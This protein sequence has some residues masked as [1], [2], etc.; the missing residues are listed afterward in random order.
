ML[1]RSTECPWRAALWR[2]SQKVA[3]NARTAPIQTRIPKVEESAGIP[4]K[5]G[6]CD[7]VVVTSSLGSLVAD[8]LAEFG[9]GP[10]RSEI[11]I[12]DRSDDRLG[13]LDDG[14]TRQNA[15]SA[16]EGID[17]DERRNLRLLVHK[18]VG[19]QFRRLVDE[20]LVQLLPL[21]LVLRESGRPILALLIEPG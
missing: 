3:A 5:L 7:V 15:H 11:G 16:Y 13:L 12:D 18:G 10:V 2:C 21:R 9:E 8:Q 20:L 1:R 19:V 4:T 14:G 6:G 17:A